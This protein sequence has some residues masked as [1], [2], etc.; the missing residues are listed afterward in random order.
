MQA[1]AA[2]LIGFAMGAEFDLVTYLATRHSACAASVCYSASSWC[3]GERD[4][5]RPAYRL[6]DHDRFHSYDP[7]LWVAMPMLAIGA[8]LLTLLGPFP[9]FA[10]R[11]GSPVVDD[12]A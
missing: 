12:P 3:D 1:G 8:L 10:A 2:L 9:K 5:D 6:D 4:C 11:S 7:F